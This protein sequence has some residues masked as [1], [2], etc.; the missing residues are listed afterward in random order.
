MGEFSDD[1]GDFASFDLDAAIA[2]ARKS[3]SGTGGGG[4]NSNNSTALGTNA[5]NELNVAAGKRPPSIGGA[6]S[7]L[8]K[9]LKTSGDNQHNDD[10]DALALSGEETLAVPEHFRAEMT[11]AL[12]RHF[13]HSDFRPGQ[14]AVLRSI[15]GDVEGGGRSVGGEG[16]RDTCVFWATG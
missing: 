3:S 5:A 9:R 6:S 12:Q 14:L 11:E 4:G 1:E 15:L 2:S 7:D 16:G 13:G 10:S 8:G